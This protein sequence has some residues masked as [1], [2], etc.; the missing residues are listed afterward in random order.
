MRFLLP[1]LR[2]LKEVEHRLGHQR[3]RFQQT[4]HLILELVAVDSSMADSVTADSSMADSVTADSLTGVA[5]V[6]AQ[7]RWTSV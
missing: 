1:S 3:V 4:S 2:Q 6:V 7:I 5:L